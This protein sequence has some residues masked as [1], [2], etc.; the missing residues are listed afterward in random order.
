[1]LLPEVGSGCP[2]LPE[3]PCRGKGENLAV[4][5]TGFYA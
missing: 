3:M 2:C 1:V 4:L 5:R